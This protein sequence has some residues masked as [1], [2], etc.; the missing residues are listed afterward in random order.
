[1]E[2]GIT[3]IVLLSVG[4]SKLMSLLLGDSAV[5]FCDLEKGMLMII[6]MMTLLSAP[7]MM[8]G[9]VSAKCP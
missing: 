1:M 9:F 4:Q 5:L 2:A 7:S 3:E 6:I 8:R